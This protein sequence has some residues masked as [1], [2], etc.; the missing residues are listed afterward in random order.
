M[1]G[2]LEVIWGFKNNTWRKSFPRMLRKYTEKRQFRQKE[3]KKKESKLGINRVKTC[4][5]MSLHYKKTKNMRHLKLIAR[6]LTLI[7]TLGYSALTI[8]TVVAYAQTTPTSAPKAPLA[9]PAP[10]KIDYG[11]GLGGAIHLNNSGFGLAGFISK[12][13]SS[14]TSLTADMSIKSEK[15]E[16]EEKYF[17]WFGNTIIPFK[18][19]YMVAVPLRVGIQHRLFADAIDESFRPYIQASAGPSLAWVSPYFN[20][21]D[22]N[23]ELDTRTERTY[24]SISSVRHG[25]G[26]FGLGGGLAIGAGFG[27]SRKSMQAIQ[28]GYNF[29]YYLKK[30]QLME[31][32]FKAGTQ[33]FGTPT[34]SIIFGR[35]R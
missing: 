28:I 24:D 26:Q 17:D 21:L 19:Q 16:Q 11:N 32:G 13:I 5:N 1:L 30:V 3:F 8:C 9:K 27:K 7:L 15:D 2:R 29:D 22:K 12:S 33:F 23:N 18:Y 31:P 34:I 6:I 4:K 25:K 14:S 20:D 10:T 35:L